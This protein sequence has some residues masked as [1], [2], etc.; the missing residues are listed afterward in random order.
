MRC[1]RHGVRRAFCLLCCSLPTLFTPQPSEAAVQRT[2]FVSPAGDDRNDGAE[3]KPFATLRRAQQAARQATSAMTGD[4]EVVLRGGV[5]RLEQTLA[6]D[7]ADSGRNGHRVIYRGREGEAAVIS[8]GRPIRGW[9]PD[10]GGR[11]KATVDVDDFRQFYVN[12][13]RAIRARGSVPPG[14][15]RSGDDGYRT[16]LLAMASWKNASDVEFCY[17]VVWCHTRCKV[18]AIR[19]DKSEAV[20]VMQQPAFRLARNKEGVQI[21]MPAYVENA[22]EL[23]DEPGEW[24][25]DRPTK[26]LYY[27]PRPGEDMAKAEAIVPALDRLAELRG[28]LDRPVEN[29]DFVGLT[30]AD[31]GWLEPSRVGHVDVQANFRL[32]EPNLLARDGKLT[33]VHNEHIKSPSNVVGRAVRGVRFEQCTFTRLGSGG[34][35]LE[36]G[37]QDNAVVGC[38][39][40]DIAGSAIQL[41]DVLKA[42]HHPD[43]P[44]TIVKNNT[45][46]NNTIHDVGVEYQGGVGVFVGYTEG[47]IVAHNEVFRL[48]YSGV[49]MGWGWGE[50]DAG[51]GAPNYHQPFRYSTPTPAQKNRIEHNHI[52]HVMQELQDGGAIYTLGNQPGTIIR[53]NHLHDNRGVPGGIY[54]DEGSGFIEVTGNL[55]HGVP[56]ALNFNNHAQNR[57]AT[58]KE[59]DNVVDQTAQASPLA[60][61]I[62]GDAGPAV[63]RSLLLTLRKRVEAPPGSGTFKVVEE[64]AVWDAKE[65][66]VIVC[67]MWTKHWCAGARRRG[68]EMAP[69]M[70]QLL[71]D[72]RKRGVLVIHA[73]SGAMDLYRDHPARKR[74]QAASRAANLPKGIADWCNQIEAEKK[75][76]YPIDQSD[77]GCDDQPS[78]DMKGTMDLHQSPALKIRDE[79]ALSDSGVEIWNLMNQRGIVNVMVLGVHTNMCVLGR[80][81][82]LRNMSQFG[83]NVVL[84]RDLTDTMYNPRAWPQVSHFRGTELIVEHIEKY[85]CPT[86]T[87]AQILGAKP[88]RFSGDESTS[89]ASS[90]TGK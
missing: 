82:G 3:A 15:I 8:G 71:E 74:A 60:A 58:C 73:P 63:R 26:T 56:R 40:H 12:G 43:D 85:V 28:T 31:A 4:I 11:W 88:F 22:L 2:F 90:P 44:R 32:F 52:H 70:N 51:G 13:R 61:K 17:E 77:G 69:R 25:L 79:D 29:L 50:E 64:P 67:D 24:Y 21:D 18:Q 10:P 1:L 41:G 35:D 53:A 38:A 37:A 62:A 34:L 57:I 46:A 72:L 65:T 80:P 47:T 84:V 89:D 76:K 49:S 55:I 45:I 23:L 83:K 6:F 42:D 30:F 39:F 87:S 5:Y 27:L 78:C 36:F 75:G 86:M 81:F 68:A 59:H 9:R 14:L 20:V 54:L 19:G 66:A 48:P 33:T 16:S 7:A